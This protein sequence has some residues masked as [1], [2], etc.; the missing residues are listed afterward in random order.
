[1][2]KG[3]MGHGG[4]RASAKFATAVCVPAQCGGACATRASSFLES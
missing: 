2:E 1:M 3:V 4:A